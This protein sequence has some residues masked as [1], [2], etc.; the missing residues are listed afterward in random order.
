MRE[1]SYIGAQKPFMGPKD[2][3]LMEESESG[4]EEKMVKATD[5]PTFS[6]KRGKIS[7]PACRWGH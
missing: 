3:E 5:A 6:R 1:Y 7:K 4:E 2:L